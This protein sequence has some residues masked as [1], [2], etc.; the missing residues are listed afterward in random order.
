MSISN[1][2][3]TSLSLTAMLSVAIPAFADNDELHYQQNQNRYI[4]YKQAAQKAISHIGSG[5]AKDIDFEYSFNKKAY[6]EV[7]V[8]KPN[9][10]EYNVKV[11]AQSG[12]IISSKLDD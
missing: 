12:E 11:D 5:M 9:G 4:S 6:F 3:I 8:L 7:E 10:Q 1:K 2:I